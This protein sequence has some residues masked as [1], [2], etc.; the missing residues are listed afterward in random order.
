VHHI[1]PLSLKRMLS[2]LGSHQGIDECV[3]MICRF[4]LDGDGVLSFEEYNSGS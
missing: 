2:Q 3:A 4:D 1:T